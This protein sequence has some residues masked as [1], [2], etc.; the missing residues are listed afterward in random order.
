MQRVCFTLQIDPDQV[1]E[2]RRRH[3]DVWPE[4]REAL[5]AAGWHNYSLF[6]RDDG[7]AVG[8]VETDDFQ[9]SLRAMDQ[10]EVND[11]WQASMRPLVASNPDVRVD[12]GLSPLP[13]IFHLP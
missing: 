5:S 8:Y 11:R 13:C 6:L 1:D 3:S 4:M 7:L 10:L 2:Y 12:E 9:Q